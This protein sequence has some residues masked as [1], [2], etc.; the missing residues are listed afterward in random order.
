MGSRASNKR[1]WEHED[2]IGVPSKRH[3]SNLTAAS[4]AQ[5]V[6]PLPPQAGLYARDSLALDHRVLPPP[7]APSYNIPP[8][9]VTTTST[10]YSPPPPPIEL[11]E[12]SQ[13]RSYSL[14]DIFE[15]R[16][17]QSTHIYQTG[18]VLSLY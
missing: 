6:S 9:P 1:T 13:R 2:T 11:L 12:T 5:Q 17:R 15:H 3:S 10:Q 14:F 8:S 4:L 16:P 7:L 18:T